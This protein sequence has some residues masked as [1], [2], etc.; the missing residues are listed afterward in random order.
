MCIG[1]GD[2]AIAVEGGDAPVHCEVFQVQVAAGGSGMLGMNV[3]VGVKFHIEEPMVSDVWKVEQAADSAPCRRVKF[4]EKLP[5][6]SA[7]HHPDGMG[8]LSAALYRGGG[9]DG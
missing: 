2:E 9:Q 1:V 8:S 5:R 6:L 7:Q 3:Q 4:L